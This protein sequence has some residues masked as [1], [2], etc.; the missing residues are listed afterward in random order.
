MKQ[1]TN[2]CM[3]FLYDF[4]QGILNQFKKFLPI[5]LFVMIICSRLFVTYKNYIFISNNTLGGISFADFFIYTFKGMK[6]YNPNDSSFIPNIPWLLIY[7]YLFYLISAYPTKDLQCTGKQILLQ[8]KSRAV[9]WL[10]KIVWCI[11]IVIIFFICIAIGI[12]FFSVLINA[13][14]S[15][16]YNPEIHMI[17]SEIV[18]GDMSSIEILSKFLFTPLFT[19]ISLSVTQTAISLVFGQVVGFT[20]NIIILIASIFLNNNYIV[21]NM[22]MPLRQNELL[23]TSNHFVLVFG[24]MVLSTTIS[25]IYFCKKDIY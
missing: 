23:L 1:K 13:Q 22:L 11:S 20:A 18:I 7:T 3:L 21:G 8:G 6:P 10:S 5:V 24:M 4:K 25:T 16:E 19:A 17:F 2:F 9:W 15:F 12:L 14:I